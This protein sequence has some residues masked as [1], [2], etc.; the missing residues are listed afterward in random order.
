M[1]NDSK[2]KLLGYVL[3]IGSVSMACLTW[4]VLSLLIG[5]RFSSGF[6]LVAIIATG[7]FAGL[8]PSLLAL[9]LGG[10]FVAYVQYLRLGLQAPALPE[11]I[12]I[13]FVLGTVIVLLTH[14]ERVARKAADTNAERLRQQLNERTI[15]DQQLRDDQQQLEMALAAGRLGTSVW[16]VRS[17]RIKSSATNEAIHGFAP[18]TSVATFEQALQRIHPSDQESLR[19]QIAK[20]VKAG[21]P[22]PFS[23][24][25]IWSD[26]STHWIEGVG[27][28]ICD[29]AGNLARIRAICADITERKQV[30]IALRDAEERFRRMAMQAP[31]GIS[32]GD[33]D[34]RTFFVNP[35]LCEIA[36]AEPE[37]I[38]GFGWQHFVHPE[39]REQLAEKGRADLAAGK[40]KTSSD[41]RFIRKDGS[42]RWASSTTSL[43][44][45]A[46]GKITGQVSITEDITDRKDAENAL[47]TKE[48]QLRGIM[49]HA[50]AV[51]WLKDL[52]GRY[53]VA[54]R[55]HQKL[56]ASLGSSIL[57]KTDLDFF[58]DS[59]AHYFIAS[60]KE[61]IQ[62]QTPHVAEDVI[63]QDD[64]PHTYRSVKFPV[65]NEAGEVIAVGGI[66]TD[67]TD[68]KAAHEGLKKKEQLLRNLIEVQE[69]EKQFLCH[70]FHDGLIQYA[71]G[72]L[73]S[74][75]GFKSKHVATD[76]SEII[77]TVIG[78][79]RKGVDDG[80]RVIRGIRPAV[81]DDSPMEA[82]LHDLID[83]FPT[84]EIMIKFDC[85]PQI[86]RLSNA[87]QTTV[88]RLVQ[89]ALNN[90]K[91][92]SGTDVVRVELRQ[93]NG[94]LHLEVRDF[95]CGFDVKSHTQGF[96][97]L[98][99]SE[100]VR[101]LGG[102][103]SIES[104]K[105][106]G[107]TIKVRLPIRAE[108]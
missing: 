46:S 97:L 56:F 49:D 19:E 18:G 88:Y 77:D 10:V 93:S 69:K 71:A 24:R 90:A 58:P 103:C 3:A 30:E 7:R 76:A 38:M 41:F 50:S 91:K 13:Y 73:M 39:D 44:H 67:I 60:D 63:D 94:D 52:Q 23:Y 107:T 70:E 31:V 95:G 6:V 5:N 75:E 21:A 1:P 86:G 102:N 37:E 9:V 26:G 81:L 79:L 64:G 14:S 68:L 25:V 101:L 33:M 83:Q 78:N 53:I 42:I 99:M 87:V 17:G 82:A 106:A 20:A 35:K 57:G 2:Q 48:S 36:G 28:F 65:M 12:V 43:V 105:D 51:I 74:L 80:R 72:S 84:S 89:E 66:S 29:A 8:K 108:E 22:S 45:D 55:C 54:N 104:E 34:G 15:L 92:H 98:G 11:I 40:T 59:M 32:Q 16:D 62:G 27:Q 96:G 47:R 61:V 4:L 100:R 85:D